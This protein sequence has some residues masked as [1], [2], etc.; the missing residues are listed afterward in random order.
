MRTSQSA[1][2]LL[3]LAA[4]AACNDPPTVPAPATLEVV[5][6][7]GTLGA[8]G[9]PLIDTIRVRL[10]DEGN[11]P[12]VGGRVTWAVRDG[13]GSVLPLADS[14]DADGVVAAIWTL[15]SRPGANELR[16]S[17]LGGAAVTFKATGDVFRASKVTGT[18]WAK[19]CGLVS[20][21]I[22]CW[23]WQS[24]VHGAPV[25]NYDRPG[26]PYL[27]LDSDAP[28]LFDASRTWVDLAMGGWQFEIC[29]LDTQ[30]EVWCGMGYTGRPFARVTGFPALS[31]ISG[32]G[33]DLCG[34]AAADGRAWCAGPPGST[35]T[36]IPG[37]A[38]TRIEMS[39]H[40]ELYCGL[41][42]DST[43]VCWGSVPPGDGTTTPSATP[44]AVS[45]GHK[46]ADISVGSSFACGR[47][48]TGE[49]WCWGTADAPLQFLAPNLVATGVLAAPVTWDWLFLQVL[50][51]SVE[52]AVIPEMGLPDFWT[53][54]L[55]GLEDVR[56]ARWP[57]E[58]MGCL[59]G[60]GDEVYCVVQTWN[61]W[62]ATELNEYLPV[63]PVRP[64]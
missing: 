23:G 8:P 6:A 31:A 11:A 50:G 32:A 12:V 1:H 51:G 10:V 38:F 35:P 9:F 57:R 44:V 56:V 19:A 64:E 28:A 61:G 63:Q 62:S 43:A 41:L 58:G 4:L 49:L 27:P 48:A 47:T 14:S 53:G 21:A 40:R 17:E 25:S 33:Y 20:G 22:W 16:V 13:G 59:L 60:A 15:G 42:V 26:T 52:W 5:Q 29:A 36:P 24:P 34:I 37:P 3:A 2:L 54:Q 55:N 18:D 7:P 30:G 46:F 39:L 45:G